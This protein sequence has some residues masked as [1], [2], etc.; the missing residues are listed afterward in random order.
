MMMG[1]TY[2]A[3]GLKSL[4]QSL[5]YY[6]IQGYYSPEWVKIISR[7]LAYFAPTP[8]QRYTEVYSLS[9]ERYKFCYFIQM[10]FLCLVSHT[11]RKT[12]VKQPYYLVR[13]QQQKS[14]LGLARLQ[15]PKRLQCGVLTGQGRP[16][17]S[18]KQT[19]HGH[20]LLL[21]KIND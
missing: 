9:Q 1:R 20:N 17:A 6:L 11:V 12:I 18:H 13:A 7:T 10:P 19:T 2:T 8:F 15:T 16:R 5:L 14:S 4:T 3:I 21:V